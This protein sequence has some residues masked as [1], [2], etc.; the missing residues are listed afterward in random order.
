MEPIIIKGATVN[1]FRGLDLEMPRG[2][3][4]SVV[5]RSGAGKS[6]LLKDVLLH[7]WEIRAGIRSGVSRCEVVLG[8]PPVLFYEQRRTRGFCDVLRE[9]GIRPYLAYL[10]TAIGKCFCDECGSAVVSRKLSELANLQCPL[11]VAV[12]V[13][14][15]ESYLGRGFSR[16]ISET[17]ELIR[18]EA[19]ESEDFELAI[20][21]VTKPGR[22][23]LDAV[24]IAKS[25]NPDELVLYTRD[26]REVFTLTPTCSNCGKRFSALT[27]E[28]FHREKSPCSVCRGRGA[29]EPCGGSGLQ[30]Y[31]LATRVLETTLHEL[32]SLELSAVSFAKP[33]LGVLPAKA[34]FN[35]TQGLKTL[36]LLEVGYLALNRQ[37]NTL[38]AGESQRVKLAKILAESISGALIALDEPTSQLHPKNV[39][40]L[41]EQ[42][43]SVVSAGNTVICATHEP[44]LI[45]AS[46]WV[47]EL[48]KGVV[49]SVGDSYVVPDYATY[50]KYSPRPLEGQITLSEITLRTLK[51][52]TV[53]LGGLTVVCGVSGSGKTTL[54]F[55]ALLSLLRVARNSF[56][57]SAETE[58]GK[59]VTS[60]KVG[61]IITFDGMRRRRAGLTVLQSLGIRHRVA[62]LYAQLELSKVKGLSG[63][64]FILGRGQEVKFRGYAF[65]ETLNLS[66]CEALTLFRRIPTI[67]RTLQR[68]DRLGL[69]YLMLGQR[70]LSLGEEKRLFLAKLLQSI[71]DWDTNCILL[72]DEPTKNLHPDEQQEL[73]SLLRE[74]TDSGHT[75]VAIDHSASLQAAADN[76]IE[77]G[78]GAGEAGGQ[79]IRSSILPRPHS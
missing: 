9:S 14:G 43:R 41:I 49:A 16:A 18:I 50:P 46:D 45:T 37:L 3:L 26:S 4:V 47:I 59:L 75:V 54:V 77:L 33:S 21:S 27:R 23:L 52:I 10:G 68:A 32:L 71:R 28:M 31:T 1:N 40:R 70:E 64:D 55:G 13:I 24:D 44:N 2:A 63:R 36:Q 73:I 30:P 15:K 78:P 19:V 74:L 22:R 8:L 38:S 42:L 5:G 65:K 60:R 69:G 62:E 67:A 29:C 66:V 51:S 11:T 72:L 57:Q 56:E 25:I 53:S 12:K 79:V 61:K 35:L 48:E 6:T 34:L 17:G 58:F 20:D 7:E 76:V 39:E